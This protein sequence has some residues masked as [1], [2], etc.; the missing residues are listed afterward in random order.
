MLDGQSA[1]PDLKKAAKTERLLVPMDKRL[2]IQAGLKALN[3]S[4]FA[5]NKLT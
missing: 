5:N 2:S 3:S 1:F 4:L